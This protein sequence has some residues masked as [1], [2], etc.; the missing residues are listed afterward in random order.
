MNETLPNGVLSMPAIE[1][2]NTLDAMR[3]RRLVVFL[4][5]F[6]GMLILGWFYYQGASNGISGVNG[7]LINKAAPDFTVTDEKGRKVR[8]SDLKGKTVMVHFWA[9]WCPPCRM[10]FP[11]LSALHTK[12]KGKNFELLAISMDDDGKSA[13]SAFRKQVS[14]D[15]PIYFNHSQDIA[16]QYGTYGL[17]ETFLIN[18]E[19][20]IVKK[21]VGPQNWNSPLMQQQIDGLM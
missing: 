14:F 19:G 13:V 4:S 6:L 9:T 2:Q 7:A 5:I 1:M 10:E 20:V 18:K 17:P 15:F 3:H 21:F 8:L 11:Y 16:D 12:M